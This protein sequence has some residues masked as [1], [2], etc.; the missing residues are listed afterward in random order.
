M[1]LAKL[2]A[3]CTGRLYPREISYYSFLV[4]GWLDPK[5]HFQWKI[6]RDP[7]GI[8]PRLS[9]V[10]AYPATNRIP[11]FMF[12][13]FLW[14][15][16]AVPNEGKLFLCTPRGLVGECS[17]IITHIEPGYWL[18]MIGHLHA[19]TV[20]PTGPRA[21][22]TLWSRQKSYQCQHWN[23]TILDLSRLYPDHYT[24]WAVILW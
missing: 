4:S 10:T 16:R 11:V 23:H 5:G 13:I 21:M 3:L 17:F 1:K 7:S 20:L 19:P 6:Q 15:Q 8:E 14:L 9:F 2:P 12:L 22:L 24:D 18:E